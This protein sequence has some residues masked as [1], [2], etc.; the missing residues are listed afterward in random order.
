MNRKRI[1]IIASSII[2]SGIIFVVVGFM[3]SQGIQV[4]Y[5]EID[6]DFDLK[7]AQFSDTH[8]DN[9]YVREDYNVMVDTVNDEEVDLLIFT[10]DMFQ[11]TDVSLELEESIT[12]L[13]SE[14]N[15]DYKLAVLGNH[16]Y[17]GSTTL[18]NRII[19]IL[20]DSGFTVLINE[21]ITYVINDQ[22]FNFIGFDDLMMGDSN[23]SD[24][25][26]EVDENAINFVLSHEPDTFD[27][28]LNTDCVAMFSGHSHGGQIR[29]PIIGDIYN[30]EGAR[31]YNDHHYEVDGK[32]LYI[33]FGMGE[34]VIRVRFYNRRQF[35][36]YNYS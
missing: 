35:E 4:N 32:D 23:Y 33:S 7:I 36:I 9:K 20:E 18:T 30:V 2:L 5:H 12:S 26:G 22:T 11:I 3:T 10:G 21:S 8:F 1:L 31:K 27:S 19:T 24:V 15:A 29:L 13:L 14:I 25:L 6:K 28:I 16:D 17:F 34:S